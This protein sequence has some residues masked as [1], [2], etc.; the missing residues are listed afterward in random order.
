MGMAIR[1]QQY[2]DGTG[3]SYDLIEHSYSPTCRAAAHAARVP[4]DQ[5]AK[6]VLLSDGRGAY[7]M[8]V[9]PADRRVDLAQLERQLGRRLA[10]AREDELP[11]LFRD[12]EPGAVPPLGRVYGL[13]TVWDDSLSACS[14]VYFE[15]GDHTD[16][17]H[18]KGKD[19]CSLMGGAAHGRF[20]NAGA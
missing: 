20:S 7:V 18:M 1:L 6:S 14:D 9:V 2:L 11:T 5:I 17:V 19:F 12:C 8:A 3:V 15:A 13:E 4:P 16:L 10:L